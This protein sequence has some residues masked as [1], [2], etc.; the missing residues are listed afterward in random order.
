MLRERKIVLFVMGDEEILE[1]SRM[2]VSQLALE[3]S[4]KIARNYSAAYKIIVEHQVDVMVC[5]PAEEQ[6]HQNIVDAYRFMESASRLKRYRD[7][8]MILISDVEDPNGYCDRELC[9]FAVIDTLSLE[10]RLCE[11]LVQ[12]LEELWCTSPHTCPMLRQDKIEARMLYIQNQNV[13]YPIQCAKVSHILASNRSMEVCLNNGGKYPV[14]YVTLQQLLEAADVWYFLQCSRSGII[15]ANYVRNIDYTNRVITMC[16]SDQ[17]AIGSTY[18][19]SLHEQF[20]TM[21]ELWQRRQNRCMF[22]E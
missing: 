5:G 10:H 3:Y 17:I 11:T 21:Q 14:R 16:N 4:V 1:R 6:F 18:V 13:I 8:P 7:T 15:N 19:R 20:P 2:V 12:A 9:C 22:F